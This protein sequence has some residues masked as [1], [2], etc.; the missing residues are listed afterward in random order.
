MLPVI[1]VRLHGGMAPKTCMQLSRVAELNG[2]TSV[3]FAEN[4]FD[5]GVLP[6]AAACAITTEQIKVGIG[7]FNP[8][9][10][11]PTLIAMEMGA[12]DELSNGR[13]ML[14]I[15]SGIGTAIERMGLSYAKPVGAVR[16]AIHIVRAM[17]RGETVTYDGSVFS[18]RN[19]KIGYTPPRPD[20]PI[21]MAAM[22][23]QA[24]RMCGRVAD[25]LMVSNMCPPAYTERALNILAESA[26]NAG[27]PAPVHVIHYVPCVARLDRNE[28]RTAVK[29]P[30]ASML[31]AY[32]AIGE[33]TPTI[34][35]AMIR[36]STISKDEFAALIGRVQAGEEAEEVLDD[37]FVDDY[38][39]AG[40]LDDCLAGVKRFAEAGASELVLSFIGDQP[41]TDMEFFGSA[42]L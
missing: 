12:L 31:A 9:N 8:Y 16:D 25:G 13:A 32:W 34:R 4:P 7:V 21:L 2:F 29:A 35:E 20:M 38:S 5:R 3:W 17:M 6:T 27:R 24:L 40:D 23:D 15:G 30:I 37:R 42:L 41:A 18:V 39:I 19:V 10:R 36:D 33:H 26:E 28:A 1:G 22:G 14:G 11:H